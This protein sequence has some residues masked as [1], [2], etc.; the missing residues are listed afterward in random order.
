MDAPFF[1]SRRMTVTQNM[2]LTGINSRAPINSDVVKSLDDVTSLSSTEATESR[3][4]VTGDVTWLDDVTDD[5]S[6]MAD[7]RRPA[8]EPIDTAS[9]VTT[10]WRYRNLCIIII[11]K[12]TTASS[13]YWHRITGVMEDIALF[14]HRSPVTDEVKMRSFHRLGRCLVFPSVLWLGMR[15]IP[16]SIRG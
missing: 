13:L 14:L 3:C 7:D 2:T 1:R 12:L 4:E 16:H 5:V 10:L 8:A 6:N 15:G 9:E 11:V